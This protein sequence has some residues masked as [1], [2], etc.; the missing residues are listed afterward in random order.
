MSMILRALQ[1]VGVCFLI[2]SALMALYFVAGSSQTAGDRPV[3][4]YK[5]FI[6]ILLTAVAVMIAIGA[7][8]AAFAAI[9][10]FDLLR[11]EIVK[12]STETATKVA[13]ARVDELVP[14]LVEKALDF[15]RDIPGPEADQIAEQFGKDGE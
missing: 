13:A 2:A 9:W 4:E 14:G 1:I 8:I 3:V 7:F 11:R 15:E 6:S 12:T 10:G 5:D